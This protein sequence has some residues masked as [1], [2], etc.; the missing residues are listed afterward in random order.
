MTA[1]RRAPNP[2]SAFSPR[3]TQVTRRPPSPSSRTT[4]DT[5]SGSSDSTAI[6]RVDPVA[7]RISVRSAMQPPIV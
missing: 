6:V 4:A 1:K 5:R 7:I 3:A 2:A